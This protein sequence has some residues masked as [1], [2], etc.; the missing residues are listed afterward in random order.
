[1]DR[2]ELASQLMTHK[3]LVLNI[4]NTPVHWYPAIQRSLWVDLCWCKTLLKSSGKQEPSIPCRYTLTTQR[5]N[6]NIE[7]KFYL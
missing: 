7:T 1:M 5:I 4:Y 6:R 3:F 2:E